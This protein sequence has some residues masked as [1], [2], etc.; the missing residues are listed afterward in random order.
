MD[1]GSGGFVRYRRPEGIVRNVISLEVASQPR[2]FGLVGA[3]RDVDAAGMIEAHGAV[4]LGLTIGADRNHMTKGGQIG[5]GNSVEI[6]PR[7]DA[8]TVIAG[9]KLAVQ[10][11]MGFR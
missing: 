6:G 10:F 1:M 8:V 2:A 3:Q 4:N 11:R 9:I 7:K 5:G